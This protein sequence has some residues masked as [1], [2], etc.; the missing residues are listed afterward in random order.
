MS[1][2][3][4]DHR[5]K[6]QTIEFPSDKPAE[7][8]NTNHLDRE[9]LR[10]Q[11]DWYNDT[12]K[13]DQTGFEI[14]GLKHYTT[15]RISIRAC[16]LREETE[17]NSTV[18]CG[19]EGH[20]Y[21]TTFRKAINDNIQK[22]EVEKISNGSLTDIRVTWEPPENPNGLLLTYTIRYKRVD[23]EHTQPVPRCISYNML[24]NTNLYVLKGLP[25]GN[26]SIEMMATSLAG[27]GNYTRAKFVLIK[28]QATYNMWYFIIILLVVFLICL[29]TLLYCFK[30]MYLTSI[31]SMKLIANVNPDYAGVTYRQDEW[32]IPRDKIIQLQEL[33]CGSFGNGKICF[34]LEFLIN[35]QILF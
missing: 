34:L 3:S 8:A 31:S 19:P 35:F 12:I 18:I 10:N 21:A 11:S 29:L 26:Y 20:H 16:R 25:P 7:S 17:D 4:K 15:Y 2:T 14:S 1:T 33:G 24:N 28:E 22:F 32:E 6:R 13:A 27:N 5:A 23:V 30:R 9:I